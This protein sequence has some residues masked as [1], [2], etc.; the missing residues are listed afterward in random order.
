MAKAEREVG[1]G[2]RRGGRGGCLSSRLQQVGVMTTASAGLGASSASCRDI[3]K[4]KDM[5][6]S[7]ERGENSSRGGRWLGMRQ[8]GQ[9]EHE[10]GPNCGNQRHTMFGKGESPAPLLEDD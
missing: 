8:Q 10:L 3:I 4:E 6:L 9:R 7:P 1:T 2:R 5:L